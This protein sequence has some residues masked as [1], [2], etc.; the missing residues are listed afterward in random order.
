MPY[1]RRK[2]KTKARRPRRRRRYKAMIPR[3]PVGGFRKSMIA[4]LKYCETL[5]FNATAINP[6]INLF[7]ANSCFDP[8]QTGV[9]H[10]PS[11][12]DRISAIYDKYT[13]L[14]SKIKV[15]PINTVSTSVSPANLMCVALSESGTL[16]SDAYTA[17]GA[18]N[19]L[20]QRAVVKNTEYFGAHNVPRVPVLR[21]YFSAK[22]HFKT[23]V[24][25]VEPYN[26]AIDANPAETAYFEVVAMSP[27][28]SDPDAIWVRIEIEYIV[29][30]SELK[31]SDYS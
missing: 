7:R 31:L 16:I 12:F 23:K 15:T 5:S 22:K 4:K 3:A 20:E 29:M 10:Q 26:A 2:P 6:S 28:G 17:G 9:G 24:L 21:K 30:F 14:G 18:N 13:V 8:N 27:T 19:V 11:N 1:Q 25:N